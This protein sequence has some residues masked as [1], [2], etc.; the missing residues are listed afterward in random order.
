[1]ASWKENNTLNKL[2][3]SEDTYKLEKIKA[4]MD[5]IRAALSKFTY[6]NDPQYKYLDK[7]FDALAKE[8]RDIEAAS[9]GKTILTKAKLTFLIKRLTGWKPKRAVDTHRS[10]IRGYKKTV[11]DFEVTYN[12]YD[13]YLTIYVDERVSDEALEE[14][15]SKLENEGVEIRLMDTETPLLK[16]L[17][18]SIYKH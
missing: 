7:R 15:A 6:R 14:L 1:M 8:K 16:F 12:K 4:E 3:E 17:K 9:E 5:N 10:N 13:T 11:G 2:R 18:V